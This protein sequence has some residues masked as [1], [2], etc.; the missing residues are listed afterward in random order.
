MSLDQ[1]SCGGRARERVRLH[2]GGGGARG[3]MNRQAE[4]QRR[5]AEG[6]C[7]AAESG[8]TDDSAMLGQIDLDLH[9]HPDRL[10]AARRAIEAE[11]GVPGDEQHGGVQMQ[12]GNPEM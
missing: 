8:A 9:L 12:P 1:D 3:G 5:Q 2:G 11:E 4:E 7:V 10:A 6:E